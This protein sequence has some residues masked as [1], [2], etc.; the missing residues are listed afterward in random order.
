M[1]KMA[2]PFIRLS[3]FK[4]AAGST[5]LSGLLLSADPGNLY[6][7]LLRHPNVYFFISLL[8]NS[9]SLQTR[10]LPLTVRIAWTW[11][12]AMNRLSVRSLTSKT[13]MA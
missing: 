10:R 9:E 5:D 3:S 6:F 12:S 4:L 13:S 7:T 11:P 8:E 2:L 1:E